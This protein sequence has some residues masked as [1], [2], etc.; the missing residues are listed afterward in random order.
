MN[1]VLIL[2]LFLGFLQVQSSTAQQILI[3]SLDARYSHL[4]EEKKPGLTIGIIQNGKKV[5]SVGYGMANIEHEIPFT[6]ETPSDI[7]SISKQLTAFATIMLHD[8]GALHLD[9]EITRYLPELPEFCKE[10]TIRHLIHH[11]SGLPDIYSLHSLKGLRPGDHVSQSD[12]MRF[13]ERKKSLDYTPG[14][15]YRYCNTAYMLLAEIVASVSN[16][17]FESWMKDN[18]FS[19]L[20]M[21]NTYIM[22]TQGEVFPGVADGY[23]VWSAGKHIK[24]YDNS[25]LQGG[26]GVY[27]TSDDMLKWIDNFRTKKIGNSN[28]FEIFLQHAFLNDGTELNYAGGI[29]VDSYRGV[30]RYT[31]NGSSAGYRSKMAYYPEYELGII[32]KSN[33]PVINYD[34]FND[35]EDMILNSILPGI[36][37]DK[38][39]PSSSSEKTESQ[40]NYMISDE[41]EGTF[42]SE[43]LELTLSIEIKD[44]SLIMSNFFYS[45]PALKRQAEDEFSQGSNTVHFI[46]KPDGAINRLMI[47]TGRASNLGFIKLH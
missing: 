43:E 18:I 29:N 11:T 12:A 3:D 32:L 26:G 6:N 37:A 42:Y 45:F 35:L 9:D 20:N 19:P 2:F 23:M 30:T 17:D 38:E 31:H 34:S 7:G 33:T 27:S 14:D 15:I 4:K 28:V 47:S 10:V 40:E 22:D 24:I 21:N 39:E 46:R 25:T 8:K 13:L 5:V 41:Y 36:I 1:K 16:Q 44:N